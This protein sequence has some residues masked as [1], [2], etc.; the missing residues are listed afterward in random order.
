MDAQT[1][2]KLKEIESRWSVFQGWYWDYDEHDETNTLMCPTQGHPGAYDGRLTA[3]PEYTFDGI[4]EAAIHRA[5]NDIATLL[6]LVREQEEEIS[7]LYS[8]NSEQ[9][10]EIR[11]L[12]KEIGIYEDDD[13]DFDALEALEK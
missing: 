10:D 5:P 7:K 9:S 13:E 4:V 3:H 11:H 12:K 6:R 8:E 2:E 1:Q